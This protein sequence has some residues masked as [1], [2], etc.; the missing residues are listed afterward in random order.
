MMMMA[1]ARGF[2]SAREG[3]GRFRVLKLASDGKFG[4]F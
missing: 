4:S 2:H 1:A 3:W